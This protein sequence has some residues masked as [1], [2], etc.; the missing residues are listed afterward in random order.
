MTPEEMQG[1][2]HARL[3]RMMQLMD[4]LSRLRTQRAAMNDSDPST[5]DAAIERA[6]AEFRD[7]LMRIDTLRTEVRLARGIDPDRAR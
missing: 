2:M 6:D 3:N 1:E 4:D 5:L 7:C